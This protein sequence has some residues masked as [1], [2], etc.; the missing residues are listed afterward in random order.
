M[1]VRESLE[2]RRRRLRE[3][4]RMEQSES[5]MR[6][7]VGRSVPRSAKATLSPFNG[8]YRAQHS[9]RNVS[10]PTCIRESK[11]DWPGPM[12]TKIY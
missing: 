4:G 5:D 7:S 2:R 6:R 8:I 3:G 1:S 12:H 10:T 11:Q 9:G